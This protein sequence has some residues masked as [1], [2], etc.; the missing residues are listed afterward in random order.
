MISFRRC[1]IC[2]NV[3]N[4]FRFG[5]GNR[6]EKRG[7][8]TMEWLRDV[9]FYWSKKTLLLKAVITRP[10]YFQIGECRYYN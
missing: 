9:R 6:A 4:H 10:R 8:S 3:S 2:G 5:I 7:I 1:S